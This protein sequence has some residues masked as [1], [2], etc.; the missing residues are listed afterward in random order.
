M[1]II[2]TA[3][4]ISGALLKHIKKRVDEFQGKQHKD[5]VI[6]IPSLFTFKQINATRAAATIAGWQNIHFIPEP[7]AAA[8][9]YCTK[10]DVKNNSKIFLFDC[11]GGTIDVCVAEVNNEMLT[12]L[13]FDGDS[14][15]G[16]RDYNTL[17]FHH[18]HAVLKHKYNIDVMESSKKYVLMKKCEEIKRTLSIEKKY[19]L[20]VSDFD[21]EKDDDIIPITVEEFR[22]MSESYKV[23]IL[24]VILQSLDKSNLQKDQINCVFQV[25]GGCRMPMIKDLLKEVFPTADH[26][27]VLDPDWVVANGAA[28]FAY[29]LNISKIELNDERLATPS[30][31]IPK[32]QAPFNIEKN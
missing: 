24:K 14:Y 29:Y 4:D 27:C 25:G 32:V 23:R 6:A 7:V 13:H 28:L 20:D 1:Q 15:L 21:P 26:R 19:W 9:V 5:V 12:V 11:G 8:L 16:G 22:A 30:Y 17:L 31:S 18:F 10:Q 3:E 2:K